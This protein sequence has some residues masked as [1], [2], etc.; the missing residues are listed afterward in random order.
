MIAKKIIYTGAIDLAT[1]LAMFDVTR[2]I[3]ITG[4]VEF[5]LKNATN[6]NTVE[7]RLEGDPAN[8]KLVQHQIERCHPKSIKG[9]EVVALA[10]HNYQSLNFLQ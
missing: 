10:F 7:L 6:E 4:E 5:K 3:E 2:K 9:K 8:I 1:A